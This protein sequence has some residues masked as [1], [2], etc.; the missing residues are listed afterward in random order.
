MYI[1][2]PDKTHL[3]KQ[4]TQSQGHGFIFENCIR[5]VFELPEDPTILKTR[6][7]LFGKYVDNENISI[8]V[9][10]GLMCVVEV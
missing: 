3:D 8:K 1:I 2:Y 7:S 5:K 4:Y 6:H 9:V 10:T